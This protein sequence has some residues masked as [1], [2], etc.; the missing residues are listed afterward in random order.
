MAEQKE[1]KLGRIKLLHVRCAFP[2]L[3]ELREYEGK[4]QYNI[5]LLVPKTDVQQITALA[6]TMNEVIE[7][8][9]PIGGKITKANQS[10][11]KKNLCVKDG[12][13]KS[14]EGYPGNYYV[15]AKANSGYEPKVIDQLKRDITKEGVIYGGCYVNAIIDMWSWT[16]ERG[17]KGVSASIVAVQFAADGER[18][19]GS[20]VDVDSEFETLAMPDGLDDV[21]AT[22]KTAAETGEILLF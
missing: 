10:P 11:E 9:W 16:H 4:S 7:E 8:M 3:I 5:T 6:K 15:H 20:G 18:F 12:D 21:E 2:N 1:R 13:D 14:T 19:S 17:G 22:G